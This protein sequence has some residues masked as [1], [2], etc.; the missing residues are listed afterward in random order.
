MKQILLTCFILVS[1][2]E[3]DAMSSVQ[4]NVLQ[5]SFESKA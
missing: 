5:S 3:D 1:E 4:F 2:N